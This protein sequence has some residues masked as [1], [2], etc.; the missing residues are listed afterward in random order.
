MRKTP[1]CYMVDGGGLHD[2]K[3]NMI[4]RSIGVLGRKEKKRTGNI[5][6]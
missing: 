4:T 6:K 1:T 5:R 3:K 2:I